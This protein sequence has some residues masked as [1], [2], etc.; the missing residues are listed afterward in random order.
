M[1]A[2]FKMPSFAHLLAFYASAAS[3]QFQVNYPKDTKCTDYNIGFNP[4]MPSVI[5]M[6]I[7]EHIVPSWSITRVRDVSAPARSGTRKIALEIRTPRMRGTVQ[8]S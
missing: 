1:I 4:P 2:V 5:T 8:A 7:L 6:D 3:A